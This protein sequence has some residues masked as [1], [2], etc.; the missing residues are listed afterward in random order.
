MRWLSILSC[1]FLALVFVYAGIDKAVHYDGFLNALGTYA[2]IPAALAPGL[3]P[4]VILAE[5]AIGLGLLWSSWR[6]R[7]ALAGALLLA[8]FTFALAIQFFV[9]PGSVCGCWFSVTLAQSDG[10]HIALNLILLGLALTCWL[11]TGSSKISAASSPGLGPQT[12][13]AGASQP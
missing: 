8:A 1:G 10:A 3:G 2:V 9:A 5:L 7:A 6:R 13:A 12:S 4:V 11:D